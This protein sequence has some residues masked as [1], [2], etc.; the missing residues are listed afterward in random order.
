MPDGQRNRL[1]LLQRDRLGILPA[2][3]EQDGKIGAVPLP[4]QGKRS[5]QFNLYFGYGL[6]QTFFTQGSEKT[7][8]GPPGPEC[9]GAGWANAH[10]EHVKYANR[11]HWFGFYGAKVRKKKGNYYRTD[12]SLKKCTTN[13]KN[14]NFF[15]TKLCRFRKGST[16]SQTR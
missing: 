10:F 1:H 7:L 14:H 4:G 5:V 3:P 12:C 8:R 2:Q 13:R 11:F 9:M 6:R 16:P 15:G